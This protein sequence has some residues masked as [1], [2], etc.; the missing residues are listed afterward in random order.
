MSTV[1]RVMMVALFFHKIILQ[2]F[3]L[4][5]AGGFDSPDCTV[6]Y[7]QKEVDTINKAYFW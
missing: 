5:R 7:S 3:T 4:V 2:R 1:I 6:A